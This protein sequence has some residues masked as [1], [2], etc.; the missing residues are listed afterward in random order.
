MSTIKRFEDL[1][2]WQLARELLKLIYDDFRDCKDF[3]F[4]NQ[5]NAAGLS[6]MNNIAEGFSRNSDKEFKQFL[7]IS[8]GSDGEVKSMYYVAEDQKYVSSQT[9]ID[10]RDRADLLLSKITNFMFYLKK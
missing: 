6:I 4:R 8:K 7:N 5:I 9:A 1:E 10:R 3:T 2:I